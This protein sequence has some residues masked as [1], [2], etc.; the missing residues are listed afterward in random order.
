MLGK[1]MKYEISATSR[2]LVP[3]YLVLLCMSIANRF[4][5]RLGIKE[6]ILAFLTGFMLILQIFLIIAILATTAIFMILRFY[7]NLLSDEGYLMFTLPVSSHHLIL[8]KLIITVLWTLISIIIIIASLCLVFATSS[9]I[10]F[11]FETIKQ[12]FTELVS[13]FGGNWTLMLI[14]MIFLILLSLISSIL[15]IYT[16]IAVGQLFTRH[17]IIGSFIAYIILYSVT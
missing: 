17:K 11:V 14:N 13:T 3:L 6:G 10:S 9:N 4:I 1:L 7:K 12:I 5:Y 8:S 2:I 16:S 15:L